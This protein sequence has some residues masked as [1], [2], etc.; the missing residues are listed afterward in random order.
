[1]AIGNI[2]AFDHSSQTSTNLSERDDVQDGSPLYSPDGRWLVF[3]RRVLEQSASTL[4][5]QVWLMRAN[6]SQQQALT[7]NPNYRYSGFAWHPD[8]RR[9]AAVRADNTHPTDPPELWL[10]DMRSGSQT[11]LVIGG[12]HPVWIP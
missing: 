9:L 2:I 5:W 11:R 3:S 8:S 4:G 12:Y 6:G 1:M 7:D 10:L